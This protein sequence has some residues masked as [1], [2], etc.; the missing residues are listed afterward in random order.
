MGSDNIV[1]GSNSSP[2]NP[3]AATSKYPSETDGLTAPRGAGPT[4]AEQHCGAMSQPRG[5]SGVL[6]TPQKFVRL[7]GCRDPKVR[8]S[9][10]PITG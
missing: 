4:K 6:S 10:D 3:A 8:P 2:R 1:V 5:N 9:G 7:V